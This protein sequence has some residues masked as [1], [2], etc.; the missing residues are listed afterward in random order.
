MP[1]HPFSTTRPSFTA[2][3]P[4]NV[5]GEFVGTFQFASHIPLKGGANTG[6][7]I[8][9]A[10]KAPS[11]VIEC[12]VNI[13]SDED[14][15]VLYTQRV[16]NRDPGDL[17]GLG[18]TPGVHLAYGTG[19]GG[20]VDFLGLK[21]SDFAAIVNDDL[22]NRISDLCRDCDR[23]SAHGMT[24]SSGDG[25]HDIHM[26]SGTDPSDP[27]HGQDRVHQDGA[28]AFYFDT[29]TDGQHQTFAT[30]VLVKFSS[31]HVVEA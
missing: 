8:Y 19:S 31:Q 23:I 24:Y 6:R 3:V 29:E 17:P 16:E 5:Y 12:A 14:T 25:I 13:R 2:T 10:L 7:H 11:G 15:E 1:R 28:I 18:F 4:K 22:Y 9:L 26:N 27:H 21:D 30:W 20:G